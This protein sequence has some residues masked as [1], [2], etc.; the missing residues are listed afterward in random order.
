[1]GTRKQN[2]RGEGGAQRPLRGEG[3]CTQ[4]LTMLDTREAGGWR[5]AHL[6]YH[7]NMESVQRR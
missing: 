4:L 5:R 1:M 6:M 2:P 3:V 7:C